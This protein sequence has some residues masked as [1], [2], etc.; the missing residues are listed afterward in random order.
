MITN[1]AG[2]DAPCTTPPAAH[3]VFESEKD[4]MDNEDYREILSPEQPFPLPFQFQELSGPKHV[5]PPDSPTIAYFHLFFTDLILTLMMTESNRY[6]QQVISSE[7]GNVPTPRKNWTRISMHETPKGKHAIILVHS[8]SPSH[9]MV[10]ENVCHALLFPLAAPLPP[11]QQQRRIARPWRTGLQSLCKVQTPCRPCKQ[12]SG[13][14]TPPHQEI[15]VDKSLVG[16]KNKTSLMQYLHS[17]HH[18]H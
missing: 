6:A 15:S 11:H 10:W 12:G 4:D 16:T 17:K 7:A 13:I 3:S 14:T 18:H 8:L 1:E 2:E 9:H 5:P